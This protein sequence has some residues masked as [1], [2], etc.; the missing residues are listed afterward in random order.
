MRGAWPEAA[1][2]NHR[3]MTTAL[4]GGTLSY[5]EQHLTLHRQGH[6]VDAW[7]DLDCSPTRAEN[8]R[9]P[10][11]RHRPRAATSETRVT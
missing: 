9:P 4:A 11:D 2:F 10:R 7:F 5:R 6:D 8:E 1:D 3:V